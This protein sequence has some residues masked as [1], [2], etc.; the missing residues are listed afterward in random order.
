VP[1]IVPSSSASVPAGIF[2]GW[3]L[4][5]HGYRPLILERGRAIPER[6]ADV[7]AFWKTN[8]LDTGSN[9]QFGEGGAGTFSDGKLNTL[10]KDRE[11][12]ND[13]VLRVFASA[14][15]PDEILTEAKPHIGTDCLRD[16]IVNLRHEIEEAGGEV[17][18]DACVESL[19]IREGHVTG[20]RMR[21]GTAIPADVVVLA[22]GHSARDTFETLLS[23]NVPMEQKDFA[24]GFRVAHP[25]SLI[26]HQQYG[27]S[28]RQEMQRLGLVPASYK[29]TASVSSGRGVYSFCMCPGGYVVNASSEEGRLAVNGMS[30]RDRGSAQADSAI[31]M[32]VSAKDFGG[33]QP[34]DGMK[35]QRGLEEKCYHIGN[36]CIPVEN[37]EDFEAC[38]AD[39]PK[40]QAPAARQLPKLC[41]MGQ[42]GPGA[43]HSLLP[44]GM[45]ARLYRRHARSLTVRYA[46]LLVRSVLGDRP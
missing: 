45:T 11:G 7:E 16:V 46:A 26:D 6:T 29:L 27:I 36:G 23:Q 40:G 12:R 38:F 4:A 19:L 13:E 39:A 22:P 25:Q 8:R 43:L 2:C 17:R 21:D 34:L 41:I 9:I 32:T 10:A 31:V 24:V 33:T 1:R 28:D 44:A 5:K 15:A 30:Y 20:V 14:G 35:F 37:F 18:F 42:Y 3:F